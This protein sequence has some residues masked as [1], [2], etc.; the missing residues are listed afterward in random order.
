I[1]RRNHIASNNDQWHRRSAPN[2]GTASLLRCGMASPQDEST[3]PP[4]VPVSPPGRFRA[5]IEG[6]SRPAIVWLAGLPRLAP[7]LGTLALLLSAL[8]LPRPWAAL[9]PVLV[10]LLSSWLLALGW[11]RL[12]PVAR[13]GRLAILSLL[14]SISLVLLAEG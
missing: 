14:A 10:L 11:P 1:L 13:L 9:G 7:F 12:A 8:L 6:A 5:R 3:L 2:R 4:S